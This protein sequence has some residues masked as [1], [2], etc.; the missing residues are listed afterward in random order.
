[1]DLDEAEAVLDSHGIDDS[2]AALSRL[3]YR[4]EWEGLSGGTLRRRE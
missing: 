1:M 4:V 3:G 2:S